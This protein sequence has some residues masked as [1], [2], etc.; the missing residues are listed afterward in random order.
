MQDVN[1]GLN[2]RANK[3][4]GDVWRSG[5]LREHRGDCVVLPFPQRTRP[6]KTATGVM[7]VA[8]LE[9]ENAELRNRVAELALQIQQLSEISI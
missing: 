5:A 2:R 8:R 4:G 3:R 9:V 6:T 7:L 1:V